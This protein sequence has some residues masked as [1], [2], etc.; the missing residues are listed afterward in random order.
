MS[1]GKGG[2]QDWRVVVVA[3]YL[4]FSLSLLLSFSPYLRFGH[5]CA[6]LYL[7]TSSSVLLSAHFVCWTEWSCRL[8]EAEVR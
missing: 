1:V 7:L 6:L 4:H 2:K 3:G 8:G 5:T